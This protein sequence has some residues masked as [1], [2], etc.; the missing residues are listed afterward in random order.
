MINALVV[1]D[2]PSVR[3][4]LNFMLP[5]LDITESDAAVGA[6][7]LAVRHDFQLAIVD[8]EL[9][10]RDGMWLIGE[11]KNLSNPPKILTLTTHD[12]EETLLSVLRAG[13]DSYCTKKSM[14]LISIAVDVTL[15]GD[16]FIDPVV[17]RFLLPSGDCGECA[18]SCTELRILKAVAEGKSNK[19]IAIANNV[20][21]T[22]IKTHLGRIFEK[23][24]CSRREEAVAKAFRMG[25]LV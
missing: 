21:P 15:R 4:G 22:T 13:A 18:L 19:Q 8:L 23:M 9:P 2:S 17:S 10:D 16:R 25:V 24:G 12:D 11:L 5:H 1:D 20:A 14:N 6:L 7:E 3:A